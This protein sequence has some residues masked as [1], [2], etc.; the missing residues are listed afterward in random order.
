[1]LRRLG[2]ALAATGLRLQVAPV[3]D[4]ATTA[5]SAASS[6]YFCRGLK[7]T[8]GIVGLE[9][10]PDARDTLQSK[11]HAVLQAVQVIDPTVQYR[12]NVEA[13]FQYWLNQ[14]KSEATDEEIEEA[15]NFQLEE[16]SQ[17]ADQELTLIPQMAEWKPWEVPEG[18][19]IPFIT[20]EEVGQKLDA[21]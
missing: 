1:M 20:E 11:A 7:A 17:M 8:T 21:K 4:A 15:L 10:D 19:K 18:H 3:A 14:L 6:L 12:K 16:L 5:T 13:T 2:S 9:V